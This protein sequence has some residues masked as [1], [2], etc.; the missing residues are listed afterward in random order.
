MAGAD[1]V[2]IREERASGISVIQQLLILVSTQP[3]R[4]S[5]G[6][7]RARQDQDC[8]GQP[9]LVLVGTRAFSQVHLFS[10]PALAVS[11]ELRPSCP[12]LP[13]YRAQAAL[14]SGPQPAFCGLSPSPNFYSLGPQPG[15][16]LGPGMKAQGQAPWAAA[17]KDEPIPLNPREPKVAQPLT[18]Q[19]T[20][21]SSE[22][23]DPPWRSKI[24]APCPSH[25]PLG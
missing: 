12:P 16:H 3:N 23:Q 8:Y 14:V 5:Q 7:F 4:M 15:S 13:R 20:P 2:P 18:D 24:L 11:E 6:P 21:G 22:A 17:S 19:C 25:K 9:S 1:G 10:S